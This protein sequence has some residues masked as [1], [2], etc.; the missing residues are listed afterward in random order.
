MDNV[1]PGMDGY[2]VCKSL[3][4]DEN[5]REIPV[6][7]LTTLNEPEDIL[8][9]FAAGGIDYITKPF[10]KE[11]LLARVVTHIR[12]KQAMDRLKSR[13]M[14]DE[15]TGLFNQRFAYMELERQMK[16]ARREKREFCICN[17][18]IDNL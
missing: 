13:A 6:I 2:N 16:I 8:R 14:T 1:M 3:K 4:E 9:A 12:L 5:T 7:F 10:R 18:I 15:K 11:E 17:F